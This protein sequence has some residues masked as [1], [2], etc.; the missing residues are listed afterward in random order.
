AAPRPPRRGARGPRR[1]TARAAH[2]RELRP[3]DSRAGPG[4]APAHVPA[5]RPPLLRPVP[6]DHPRRDR[7][8][9]RMRYVV[10]LAGR[11]FDVVVDGESITIDGSPVSAELAAAPGSPLRHL[12]A[13]GRG[14]LLAARRE[15]AG[16]W[17]LEL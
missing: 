4:P 12:L 13:E 17:S 1:T 5:E 2:L 3:G 15:G 16:R 11:S 14:Y 9:A 7:R 8:G 10:T 6:P